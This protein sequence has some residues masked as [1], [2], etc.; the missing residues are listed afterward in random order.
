MMRNKY[1]DENPLLYAKRIE[2]MDKTT[3]YLFMFGIYK[4]LNPDNQKHFYQPMFLMTIG[5]LIERNYINWLTNRGGLTYN[6]LQ[7]V[8]ELDLRRK[9]IIE[10]WGIQPPRYNPNLYKENYYG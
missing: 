10:N 1:D 8:I 7:K 2:N 4:D 5:F 9:S 6:K 3:F